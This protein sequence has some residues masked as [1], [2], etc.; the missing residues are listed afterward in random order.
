MAP[1]VRALLLASATACRGQPT[2]GGH[3]VTIP[4]SPAR[5]AD[6][7]PTRASSTETRPAATQID[8]PTAPCVVD[9]DAPAPANEVA[10]AY[11]GLDHV[12]V[13]GASIASVRALGE[14]HHVK[15][16]LGEGKAAAG[17][18]LVTSMVTV[19]G[20]I[21][22]HQGTTDDLRLFPRSRVVR[23]GWL[24]YDVLRVASVSGARVEPDTELP[25]W[26]NAEPSFAA[27][28]F[29]VACTDVTPFVKERDEHQPDAVLTGMKVPLGDERGRKVAT[30]DVPA[31]GIPVRALGT[32]KGRTKIRFDVEGVA[33]GEG[34]VP[35]SRVRSSAWGGLGYGSGRG[36]G[37]KLES[38]TCDVE[39]PL[40][41]RVGDVTYAWGTLHAKQ[42]VTG[43]DISDG[44]FALSVGGNEKTAPFVPVAARASCV[45]G[46][47]PRVNGP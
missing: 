24:S 14:V 7:A 11:V 47:A 41:V 23:D 44:S 12:Y 17:V 36:R 26:I 4:P 2:D 25:S 45:V 13:A 33:A 20:A 31:D 22:L 42:L 35:S 39:T 43:K 37:V 34:W 30:L 28:T 38:L 9:A 8:L 16:V 29:L 3:V 5:A 1:S 19:R 21:P 10:A 18:E 40:H 15:L 46:A 32:T 27:T 6:T